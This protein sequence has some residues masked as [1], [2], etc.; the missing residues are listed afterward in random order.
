[1][2]KGSQRR[3]AAIL[4]ADV[5]SYSKLM[6]EDEAATLA[7]LRRFRSEILAPIVNGHEGRVV[8]S[9]G[10]GWLVEFPSVI[11]GITCAIAIQKALIDDPL[12]KLRMGLHSGDV[13][14]EDQDVYGDGV[15]VAARL[16]DLAEPGSIAISETAWRSLDAKLSEQFTN[17]GVQNLKNIAEPLVAYGWGMSAFAV[18]KNCLDLPDKPSI[19]VLAFDN[20]SGDADQDFIAEGMSEDI[21][22]A[23]AHFHWFFVISRNTSFSYKGR[24]VG[25]KQVAHELGVRYVLEGS[26]RKVGNRVRVSAQLIDAVADHN[27][28]AERFDGVIEDIFD[29]QDE[30]TQKN[31]QRRGTGIP[32]CGNAALQTHGRPAA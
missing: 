23:L 3:L 8:K 24:A 4:A 11:S 32:F 12:I 28:W 21:I 13:S 18:Q 2:S 26:L 30:I 19:A 17:L 29:L 22:S 5:A 1:M 7:A 15:N 27:V 14:F 6:G 25:V 20:L 31:C 16:Q 9:M 10:D